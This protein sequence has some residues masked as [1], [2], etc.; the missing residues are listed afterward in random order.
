MNESLVSQTSEEACPGLPVTEDDLARAAEAKL[1]PVRRRFVTHIEDIFGRADKSFVVDETGNFVD[2]KVNDLWKLYICGKQDQMWYQPKA[3]IVAKVD[4]D[5]L[6]ISSNPVMIHHSK[7]LKNTI[8]YLIRRYGGEYI[9]LSL[10][11]MDVSRICKNLGVL[12][13]ESI[14]NIPIR[15]ID[16][17][18]NKSAYTGSPDSWVEVGTV[19]DHLQARKKK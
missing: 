4:K 3:Y 8:E 12:E 5:G 18:K 6:Q 19:F 15:M 2:P 17:K 9:S 10:A 16:H 11:G 13:H 14:K 7:G 1:T